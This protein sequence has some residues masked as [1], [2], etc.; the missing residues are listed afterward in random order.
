MSFMPRFNT[1]ILFRYTST[2]TN[3]PILKTHSSIVEAKCIKNKYD[4]KKIF[5]HDEFFQGVYRPISIKIL[6]SLLYNGDFNIRMKD[7]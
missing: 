6:P 7:F 4:R 5:T 1:F 2:S 3:N